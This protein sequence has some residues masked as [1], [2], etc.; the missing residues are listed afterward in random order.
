MGTPIPRDKEKRSTFKVLLAWR[1]EHFL[2]ALVL[3]GASEGLPGLE[4]VVSS[5]GNK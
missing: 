4:I 2:S 5:R 3:V 1:V